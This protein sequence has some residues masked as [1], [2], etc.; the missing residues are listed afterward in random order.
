MTEHLRNWKNDLD[1][2][3]RCLFNG[4]EPDINGLGDRGDEQAV[5]DIHPPR[6]TFGPPP[7]SGEGSIRH[8]TRA[9]D[10][11][12]PDKVRVVV[13]GQ[14]PYPKAKR[15]TGRAF[16]DG[17]WNKAKNSPAIAASLRPLL[18]SAAACEKPDLNLL[19]SEKNRSTDWAKVKE[20]IGEGALAPPAAPGHFDAL[21]AKGVL[22]LN[23]A[24]TFT[25]KTKK[26]KEA[27]QRVWRP[28]MEHLIRAFTKSDRTRPI[29]FLMLG[30][31]AKILLEGAVCKL[32]I[33]GVQVIRMA[34][35][36]CAHPE[37][38]R[39]KF[40][41]TKHYFDYDN[42][43]KRVNAALTALGSEQVRWWPEPQGASDGATPATIA[44]HVVP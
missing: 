4:V 22:F 34:T 8:M 17:A 24:W 40:S 2:A 15:A 26:T 43:L 9:F 29:V 32:G 5:S 7:R 1:P 28:V 16:E 42:P 13:I 12:V 18:V 21:A 23:A 11:I 20:K 30:K 37:S 25:D 31:D 19:E 33:D 6:R 35:V 38:K 39:I 44:P 41:N 10:G 3:W 27:H 36:F 14:D